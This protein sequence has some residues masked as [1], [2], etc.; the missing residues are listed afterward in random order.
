[1]KLNSNRILLG[2]AATK[3]VLT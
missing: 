3:V 1:M 2:Y